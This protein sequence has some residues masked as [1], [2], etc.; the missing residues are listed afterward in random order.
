MDFINSMRFPFIIV[1]G[2]SLIAL[3]VA[4]WLINWVMA[5][6]TGTDAMRKISDAIKIGFLEGMVDFTENLR[7]LVERGDV[8][9]EVALEVA[10]NPDALKMAL[11]KK[12]PAGGR[13]GAPPAG[14]RKVK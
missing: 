3:A 7:Q 14:K 9:K 4:F 13:P 8:A 2:I 1:M 5:K 6:D 10:P 11:A 12:K